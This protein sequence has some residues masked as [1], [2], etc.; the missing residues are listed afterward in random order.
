MTPA[1]TS[2]RLSGLPGSKPWGWLID[3][4]IDENPSLWRLAMLARHMSWLAVAIAVVPFA[5][6]RAADKPG[7]RE[8]Q[9]KAF[10]EL[11]DKGDFA[12]AVQGF[13][14]TMLK[15]MPA[16]EL[17]KTWEKVVGDAGA[18]KKTLGT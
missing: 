9:A 10:I 7:P 4:G 13:D 2:A 16:E 18:F 14:A 6:A 12:K 3:S 5:N 17:K 11:L 8:E 1:I 15:V